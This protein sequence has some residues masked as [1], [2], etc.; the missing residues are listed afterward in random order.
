MANASGTVNITTGSITSTAV[1]A[2]DS[3]ATVLGVNLT[4]TSGTNINLANN[5]GSALLGGGALT[6][7]AGA[8]FNVNMGSAILDYDGTIAN[9]SGDSVTIQNQTG[10]VNID[11]TITDTGTGITVQ[12]HNNGT[13]I[14][15]F[16]GANSSV[17]TGTSTAINL[18]TNSNATINFTGGGL[19]IDTTTLTGFNATGGGTVNVTGAANTATST[20]ATAV[21]IT[22]TIIGGSGVT[23]QSINSM[24]ASS[25]TVIILDDTGNGTFT[26]TGTGTTNQS[27]GKIDNK[28]GDAITLNNTDGLVTFKNMVIEDHG[29]MGA[30]SPGHEVFSVVDV[31]GGLTLDNVDVARTTDAVMTATRL[32]DL[33]I[34]NNSSFADSNRYAT[35]AD[36]TEDMFDINDLTGTSFIDNSTFSRGGE[37]FDI[38]NTTR[39]ITL[40]KIQRS[41]FQDSWKNVGGNGVGRILVDIVMHNDQNAVVHVGDPAEASA[42]LGNTFTNGAVASLRIAHFDGSSTGNIDAIVS[43]NTFQTTTLDLACASDNAH[44]GLILRVLGNSTANMNGIISHNNFDQTMNADGREGSISVFFD[45]PVAGSGGTGQFRVNDNSMTDLQNGGIR[46]DDDGTSCGRVL[47]QDNVITS[48]SGTVRNVGGGQLTRICNPISP[49]ISAS[50]LKACSPRVTNSGVI[51]HVRTLCW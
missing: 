16:S 26:V 45:A 28:T 30:A 31:D 29:N 38:Q 21:N 27:G 1:A 33:N 41:T 12:T 36:S 8:T 44:G 47:L 3:T 20:T 14:I 6:G 4:S 18:A 9:T 42:A 24:M 39:D 19:D 50:H 34:L 2:F 11:G 22:D 37:L 25:N 43:R 32:T 5:T 49:S 7:I 48:T 15:T 35:G 40:L 51:G 23:F 13:P 46:I 10:A 17:N